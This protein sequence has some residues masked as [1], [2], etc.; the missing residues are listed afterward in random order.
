MSSAQHKAAR[1]SLRRSPRPTERQR[2]LAPKRSQYR[3]ENVRNPAW[4]RVCSGNCSLG[5]GSR[6][7]APVQNARSRESGT[8]APRHELS[9]Q[10][11]RTEEMTMSD[12]NYTDP[13]LA[14]PLR[15][16]T[17]RDQQRMGE[18]EQSNAMWGWV[19]GG[20]VLALVLMFVFS[21][22]GTNT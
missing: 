2:R 8:M 17:R 18:L 11:L 19:A 10:E 1:A 3:R 5:L 6:C 20:I 22:T 12:P 7:N 14:P 13:R 9:L 4:P 15:E 21:N 16:E